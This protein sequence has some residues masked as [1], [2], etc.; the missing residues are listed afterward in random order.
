MDAACARSGAMQDLVRLKG[1]TWLACHNNLSLTA[2][3]A[4]SSFAITLGPPWWAVVPRS[5]WPQGLEDGLKPFWDDVYGDRQQE[6][7][8]IGIHMD[9]TAVKVALEQCLVTDEELALGPDTWSSWSDP[10]NC[11]AQEH[12]GCDVSGHDHGGGHA[13][14]HGHSDAVH[15]HDQDSGHAHS[16]SQSHGHDDGGHGCD[17]HC[18]D[19]HGGHDDSRGQSHGHS[20]G[21]YASAKQG[22]S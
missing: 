5:D 8:C 4:G 16:H 9:E 13:H 18:H 1:I 14:S 15:G 22:H 20:H 3:F 6:L 10:W 7:V 2:A 12:G 21:G 17:A 19:H 11:L